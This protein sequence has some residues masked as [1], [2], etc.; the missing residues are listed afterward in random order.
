VVEAMV[1][2]TAWRTFTNAPPR[3]AVQP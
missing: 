2:P 3:L 1:S